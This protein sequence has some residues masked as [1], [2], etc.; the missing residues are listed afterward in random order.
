MTAQQVIIAIVVVAAVIVAAVL[1]RKRQP[2]APAVPDV[3]AEMPFLAEDAVKW[4]AEKNVT[5]DFTPESV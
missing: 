2:L 5:L 1:L 4:A 3:I